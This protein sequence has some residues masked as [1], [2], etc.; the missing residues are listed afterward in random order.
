MNNR[1]TQYL[2]Q[3]FASLLNLVPPEIQQKCLTSLMPLISSMDEIKKKGK[4]EECELFNIFK[5]NIN[6]IV[7][8]SCKPYVFIVIVIW[9]IPIILYICLFYYYKKTIENRKS[10]CY[11]KKTFNLLKLLLLGFFILAIVF[12][13]FL[14]N[15]IIVDALPILYIIIGIIYNLVLFKFLMID[16]K[17]CESSNSKIK[18]VLKIINISSLIGIIYY[19]YI[20]YKSNILKCM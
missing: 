6:S 12:I 4:I 7:L 20:L 1:V 5:K 14:L 13:I 2:A 10:D 15:G 11:N 9:L 17:N 16:T 18:L 19:I 8:D 3:I